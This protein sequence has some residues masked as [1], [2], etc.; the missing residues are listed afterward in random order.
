MRDLATAG[1]AKS[2][3]LRVLEAESIA[4]LREVVAEFKRPVLLYSIGKDS[5]VL[6]H[7]A[8]KAFRP[9]RIPFRVLHVDTG[10]K[11]REMIEFRELIAERLRL[12]LI[13]HINRDGARR[14]INP[15]RSGSALHTQIMKTDALKQALD[16]YGFDVA[17]GGGRRDEER[18]RAKER[19]LSF[20]SAGHAW[21]PRNQRPEPWNLFNTRIKPGESVRAFPLSN[22]TEIDVW[23]YIRAEAIEVVQLYFA[24][25]RP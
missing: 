9:G 6:L 24:R 7:L 21:D 3:H 4:I 14:G 13:V 8:H 10:W 12:E 20:R 15:V 18:S 1:L 5:S 11:F 25:E 2:R 17:I 22:W 23:E 16:Q 19:I